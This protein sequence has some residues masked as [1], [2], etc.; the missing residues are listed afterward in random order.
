VKQLTAA[1]LLTA[2]C[3]L[4]ACGG[5][6]KSSE[7]A[8]QTTTG[9]GTHTSTDARPGGGGS[10]RS[11]GT[12]GAGFGGTGSSHSG[13]GAQKGS[14]GSGAPRVKAPVRKRTLLRF[15]TVHYRQQVWYG[16]LK[17]LQIG[18]GG[19]ARVYL[20]FP[21]ESDDEGPPLMACQGVLSYGRQINEVTVYGNPIGRGKPTFI[22]HC[23]GHLPPPQTSASGQ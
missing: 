9:D 12:A 1:L 19:H 6:S 21:P 8:A 14:G 13:A 11:G 22:K 16:L 10:S 4:M 18:D 20:S 15:I 7:Q 17:R 23:Q 5:G 2:A 3:G